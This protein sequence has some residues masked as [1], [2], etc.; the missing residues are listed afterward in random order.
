VPLPIAR[1][2]WETTRLDM[3]VDGRCVRVVRI[4]LVRARV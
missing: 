1:P 3:G 2:P 4:R